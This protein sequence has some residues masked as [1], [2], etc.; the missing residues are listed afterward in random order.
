MLKVSQLFIYPIKSLGGIEV[1]QAQITDR[2]FELDRRWMLVDSSNRFLSQR[3]FAQMALLRVKITGAGLAVNHLHHA[4]NILCIP[5]TPATTETGYF[6][7]WDDT[8]FGQYVSTE[9]DDWFTTMLQYNCR[10]VYMPDNSLRQVDDTYA[11]AKINSFADAYPYL[12]IGQASMDDLNQRAGNNFS[13][14]RFR[15]NIVFSGGEAYQEDSMA[16]FTINGIEFN[17]VKI[18]ARCP[19]PNINQDTGRPGKEPIRTLAGYRQKNNKVYLGQNL[20]CNGQGRVTVGDVIEVL[21]TK[22]MP[23]SLITQGI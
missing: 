18:C 4:E 3:E 10:L 11:T 15:P 7:V 16:G 14:N 2:G 23:N 1:T 5:F 22:E 12:I 17:G 6:T 8:C 20:I 9:A 19:V 21:E 13:I